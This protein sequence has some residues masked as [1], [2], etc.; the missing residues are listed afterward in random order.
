MKIDE[1]KEC[2]MPWIRPSTW[3]SHHPCDNERFHYA[4]KKSFDL[5]GNSI[6]G[7]D[8]LAAFEELAEKYHPNTVEGRNKEFIEEYAIRA[9]NISSYIFDTCKQRL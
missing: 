4:L 5:L 6:S 2:F 7:D 3:P 9:E 1:L 8:F